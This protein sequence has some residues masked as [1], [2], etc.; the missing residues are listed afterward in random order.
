MGIH[1]A[2]NHRTVYR[3]DRRISLG[4]QIVR[5]RPA[6]HC[7]TPILS[8]SLKVTPKQHFLNWQQ[9]PQSNWLA[10]FVFPEKTTEFT[11]EVD[12]VAD[13]AAINPFDFFLEPQAERFP[14]VYEPWLH[15]ELRPFLETEEPGPLLTRL[16]ATIDRASQPTVGFLVGLNQ[17]LQEAIRYVIRLEPGVQNCEETLARGKGSCRDSAWLLVQVL[18]HLGLAARFVSGYLIQLTPDVKPLEGPEGPSADFTDLHAWTEVYLPGA[19]WIGLD[20]TSG[21]LAGEGHI[22]LAATPDPASAAPVAGGLDA[23]E[24]SF[25]HH[26]Q[27]TRIREQPRVTRPYAP[28]QWAAIDAL[29]RRIDRDLAD[30]DVRL[31]MGGEPTF[32]AIDDMDGA[33][34]TVAAQGPTKRLL[35]GDLIRRLKTRFGPGGVLHFGQG[36]WYPG[37][38][39]PRWALHLWWRRDGDALWTHAEYQADERRDYGFGLAEAERFM[40]ALAA[41]LGVPVD[42]ARATYE[43]PWHHL[44]QERALPVN[45]DP[46]D[47]RLDDPEE[48]ARLARVFERGLDTPIGFALPLNRRHEAHGPVWLSSPW[49]TRSDRLFLVPGDSPVGYRLPLGSL[50]WVAPDDRPWSWEQDPFDDRAPLPAHADLAQRAEL[51]GRTEPVHRGGPIRMADV[52]DGA[53]ASEDRIPDRGESAWWV[54]RT[55]LCVE[56][57]DGRLYVFLPPTGVLEDWVELLA[58]VEATAVALDLPVVLEGYPPPKDPRLNGIAV[59]PD[60]GVI[61]VNIHP[62]HDWDELARTT[63]ALYEDARQSRLG[64]EKFALDGRHVGTGGGNHIVVGGATPADSPFLRRPD[65][66]RSLLTYWQNH[67]ALSYLF[68]G[69][70][71]GPTSQHPRV[72]EARHDSLYELEIAFGVLDGA[73][74][75]CPPWLVDRALRHLLVDVQGNTHRTEFCIDKL[76]SPDS[77]TGRLGLLELRSFEMPPHAQM[78]LV[79]QL[80]LRALIG[81]FWREPWRARLVRWGTELNDRWMLPHFVIQDMQDVVADLRAAGYGFEESWFA[82]HTTFRFPVIGQVSHR[83]LTLELRT[84]LEPWHVLGEEPGGGGTVRYVDSSLERVQVRLTGAPGERYAVACNGRRVPLRPTGTEGE[85]VAGVRFR[86]WQPPNCL[87]PTIGVHAPLVFDIL[88]T[89]TGRSIGGCTYHVAHPGG[90]NF[91]TFPVNANEAEGRRLAR[92]FPFG[93]TPGPMSVPAGTPNPDFPLTLDLR[94]G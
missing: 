45:V 1:V 8:Y 57:R 83:G 62:A 69:L 15:R 67:P 61:E 33:E 19:G 77:A 50:P 38:S 48:R 91:T 20:P 73:G 94:L 32:V 79:Q 82:P 36:K 76:Y 58:A 89:W 88:D 30:G 78:S 86:A 42:Y 40:A 74:P 5:L 17:R 59:T 85:A 35:G 66:L 84:A 21:L 25:E 6:P 31:T 60:P 71:I 90:R 55:A 11:L 46:T 93:H 9:D 39:L 23:C 28:E 54:V 65:L 12:L 49:P 13:M 52:R 51:K 4:P 26:M 34:W 53:R 81:W 92:F 22:P 2:L 18:R 75:D 80:L 44:R 29:G 63:T 43:D 68:S 10:R 72:D 14:F 64:T 7:R 56:P 16:L 37:E 24:V 27:V 87:H 47:S 70:F 41:R 3:Y